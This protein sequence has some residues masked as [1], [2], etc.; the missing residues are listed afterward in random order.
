MSTVFLV[1]C[2]AFWQVLVLVIY[3]VRDVD[4]VARETAQAYRF[5]PS[6]I[7]TTVLWPTALP[8]VLT[9][10]RLAAS[11]ALVLEISGELIVGSPCLG[12]RIVQ[13]QSGGAIPAL[14]ALLVVSGYLGVAV[15]LMARLVERKSLRWHVSVRLEGQS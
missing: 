8:Y 12:Q 10:L 14:Y 7:F 3:G 1:V 2:A 5:R 15:N 4:P 9:G 6:R 11:I 13:A